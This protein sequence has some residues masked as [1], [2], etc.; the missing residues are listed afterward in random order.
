MTVVMTAE[1]IVADMTMIAAVM[2]M[3]NTA[4]AVTTM[5][6]AAAA[7]GEDGGGDDDAMLA[8][9]LDHVLCMDPDAMSQR[10]EYFGTRVEVE[11]CLVPQ[12]LSLSSIKFE[13]HTRTSANRTKA[14]RH[15]V[16]HHDERSPV[17][18]DP[19]V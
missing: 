9:R 1:M 14:S 3:M 12:D 8:V 19:N 18:F 2:T 10:D 15:E 11:Q 5:T 4:A 13:F 7:D 16:Q 6:A 17:Q